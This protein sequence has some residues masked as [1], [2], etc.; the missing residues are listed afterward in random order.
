MEQN[1]NPAARSVRI[2]HSRQAR[3]QVLQK[4]SKEISRICGHLRANPKNSRDRRAI[5][6]LREKIALRDE[7][8]KLLSGAS[9]E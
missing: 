3:Q 8:A 1:K 6:S 2:P 4:L 7:I 5:D 9:A